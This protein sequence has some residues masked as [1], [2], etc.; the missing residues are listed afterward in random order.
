MG[1]AEQ[2]GTG[3]LHGTQPMV[4]GDRGGTVEGAGHDSG[5]QEPPPPPP[6]PPA[7]PTEGGREENQA[8]GTEDAA[9]TQEMRWRD[10][11][12][13]DIPNVA[14]A[15]PTVGVLREEG[16]VH[17]EG[18]G[19]REEGGGA[20]DEGGFVGGEAELPRSVV[21]D[22]ESVRHREGVGAAREFHRPDDNRDR[23]DQD[24]AS[25]SFFRNHHVGEDMHRATEH[26]KETEQIDPSLP[27]VTPISEPLP[28][29]PPPPPNAGAES[30]TTF[31]TPPE[32]TEET[33]LPTPRP[34]EPT[35]EAHQPPPQR[36]PTEQPVDPRAVHLSD[37]QSTVTQETVMPT[38]SQQ[39]PLFRFL[40]V[41]ENFEPVEGAFRTV[42]LQGSER[43]A[44]IFVGREWVVK[45]V[46]R[47]GSPFY[48]DFDDLPDV[49][50]ID[51]HTLTEWE[52]ELDWGEEEEEM[53][54]EEEEEGDRNEVLESD[55]DKPPVGNN[56]NQRLPQFDSNS[57]SVDVAPS[58]TTVLF[59]EHT[60][61]P[62]ETG[63]LPQEGDH[64]HLHDRAGSAPQYYEHAPLDAQT[65]SP[66]HDSDHASPRTQTG[67]LPQD[68][69]HAPP[70][71]QTG[72][73]PQNGGHIPPHTQTGSLPQEGGHAPPH[74]QTGSLPQDGGHAP[75]HAQM[76]SLPQDGDHAPPHAQTGSLP[77]EG[78]HAPPHSQKGSH[79][80]DYLN[81]DALRERMN[82]QQQQ[83]QQD[84]PPNQ[85]D[86]LPNQQDT[87]PNHADSPP[88]VGDLT[89]NVILTTVVAEM[90]ATQ[91]PFP[92][93]PPVASP[94][95][96]PDNLPRDH[97]DS[98]PS[99]LTPDNELTLDDELTPN[100]ESTPDDFL[101]PHEQ[102]TPDGYSEERLSE[103]PTG[104]EREEEMAGDAWGS[105]P[106]TRQ[107]EEEE[108]KEEEGKEE[109][110]K[111][112]REYKYHESGVDGVHDSAPFS[113][114]FSPPLPPHDTHE[115][116][117]ISEAPE[118]TVSP[119]ASHD[120]QLGSLEGGGEDIDVTRP[121]L[122][123]PAGER[124]VEGSRA[125][126]REGSGAGVG[127]GLGGVWGGCMGGVGGGCVDLFSTTVGNSFVSTL[128][129]I[130]FVSF[131]CRLIC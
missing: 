59:R 115:E 17:D 14:N 5:W 76:G 8:E 97:L 27:N 98:A 38:Q 84:T 95:T 68:G 119:E 108:G 128:V 36:P 16:G 79:A 113:R 123:P 74:A 91:L 61:L 42:R 43:E 130:V 103:K 102:L 125:G 4:G 21:D 106:K 18:G 129:A 33:R 126:V 58:S 70:H 78:G 45:V 28:F 41:P 81:L 114:S 39:T 54:E 116:D 131:N 30:E 26:S 85:Q 87:P 29:Q 118:T 93:V 96:P 127:R 63:S 111:E 71:A 49:T 57:D 67:S 12:A 52:G 66:P 107:E 23:F 3:E 100:E 31:Y 124:I 10:G 2:A 24:G 56:F 40:K 101:T 35:A 120:D 99:D 104:L 32:S 55:E 73:L 90:E 53:E 48:V 47:G 88:D 121:P 60:P 122:P 44:D 50:D 6:P 94:P 25:N 37:S 112:E 77:Q 72:S 82:R 64:A 109:E 51:H 80:G 83:L 22:F 117:G 13:N 46:P 110:G 75:P 1:G 20:R 105:L 19:V 92:P 15:E 69:D 65:G 89:R 11:G 9:R 7:S 34:P 62:V 86:T